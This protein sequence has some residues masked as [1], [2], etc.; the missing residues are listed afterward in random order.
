MDDEESI[1][2]LL[3][4]ELRSLGYSVVT[5][6]NG[7]QVLDHINGEGTTKHYIAMMFDLTVKGGMGGEELI[8]AVRKMDNEIPVFVVSGYCKN[9]VLTDP[10]KYGFTDVLKKPFTTKHLKE[11]LSRHNL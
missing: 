8:K 6:K 5:A 7:E 10:G 4:E 1:R 11:L 2:Q 9:P 3:S